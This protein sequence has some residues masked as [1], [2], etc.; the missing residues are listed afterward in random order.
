[1]TAPFVVERTR[2]LLLVRGRD[3]VGMIQ[4]LATADVRAITPHRGAYSAFL[5]AKGRMVADAR[6]FR[7]LDEDLESPSLLLDTD[8]AALAGLAAHI[9]HFVPPLFAR[10]DDVSPDH[11]VLGV[12]GPGASAALA[13]AGELE[14]P[15]GEPGAGE[16]GVSEAGA[17]EAG[18]GEAGGR[19]TGAVPDEP[20]GL[21]TESAP[22]ET[23][24]PFPAAPGGFAVRT[25]ITG[26]DGWDLF[27]P[28]A[29]RE[30]TLAGLAGAGVRAGSPDTLEALRV[31]AGQPRWGRELTEDVIPLEAGLLERALSQTKGCYTGQEVIV[32][33]L[34]RGHVNRHLRRL[35]FEGDAPEPGTELFE[36]GGDRPRGVVTSAVQN[37]AGALGL[38]Y[39]RREIDPPA[40]LRVGAPDGPVVRVEA[41]D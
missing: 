36:A 30:A 25:R 17:G 9:A 22:D 8:P 21:P 2:G 19:P 3:P 38:G 37:D 16:A 27:V 34:H 20:G 7:P 39:V 13:R 12:Y 15:A 18:A 41:L 5:T 14:P 6:I 1:M 26:D 10:A 35:V 24:V 33:I 32:R 29:W 28:A 4:G 11:V 40:D 31:A 23:V